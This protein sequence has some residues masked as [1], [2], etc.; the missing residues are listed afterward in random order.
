VSDLGVGFEA[1]D[2]IHRRGRGLI[3]MRERMQLVSGELSI[4]SQP[5]GGTTIHARVPFNSISDSALAA[6]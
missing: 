3:S 5:S 6:G 4:K 2:A 1:Q